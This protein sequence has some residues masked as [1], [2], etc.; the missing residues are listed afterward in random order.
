MS[1]DELELILLL[2]PE[3]SME[4]RD[5]LSGHSWRGTVDSIAPGLGKLWMFAELGER[6]L[7]DVEVHEIEK[8]AD[9]R[10]AEGNP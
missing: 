8:L 1:W 3:D 10:S 7:V 9:R 2:S 6:K 5:K 4:V